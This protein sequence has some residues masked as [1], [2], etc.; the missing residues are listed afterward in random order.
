M[1]A[2]GKAGAKKTRPDGVEWKFQHVRDFEIAELFEFAEE[3][4]FAV[5]GVESR[6]GLANPEN[7][8]VV[9]VGAAGEMNVGIRTEEKGAK[10]GFATVGAKDSE[11]DGEEIGAKQG[12]GLVAGSGA[13]KGDESFLSE[14][15][16]T[17]KI[18]CAAAEKREDRLAIPVEEFIEGGG[19]AVREGKHELLVG[20]GGGLCG[21]GHRYVGDSPRS[22]LP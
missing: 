10:R 16:S 21:V 2:E 15:F 22:S 14:F 1:F 11:S 9:F 6:E 4:D 5:E 3:Q 18:G 17:R 19:V 8:V 20:L 7:F 13:K 12:A